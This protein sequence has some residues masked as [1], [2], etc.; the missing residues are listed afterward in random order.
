MTK[1][2]TV[3]MSVYHR[4]DLADL[5]AALQSIWDQTI[6]PDKVLIVLDG[7]VGPELTQLIDAHR[8]AWP[9]VLRTIPLAANQGLGAALQVG[10]SE[11]DTTFVA[12]L[13]S[14][15][16]AAP[17]RIATQLEY[18][19][20]HPEL[21]VLGTTV[22]EFDDEIF[23]KT[24]DLEAAST[25]ARVL[26]ESHDGIRRYA[27]INSPVNHPSVMVRTTALRSVGGYQ[28][29]HLMEDYDLWARLLV[30]GYRFHNLPEPL[31][32]FRTSAAQLGRRTGKEILRAEWHMQRNLVSY[33]LISWPRAASNLLIRNT[34]R[35]LPQWLI[36]RVNSL[37]FHRKHS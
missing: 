6:L 26:P 4:T 30:A 19:D 32:Y 15:D 3:L 24:N 27:A 22:Q 1:S 11:V 37:L 25:N 5:D 10:L 31:T 14:D 33:G 2:V 34:Y 20:N 16:I 36:K 12:R 13:D 18:F 35:L 28:T 23:R 29:V 8:S 9:R 17:H 7:P 21:A